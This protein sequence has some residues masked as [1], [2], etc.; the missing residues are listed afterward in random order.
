VSFAV[1]MALLITPYRRS[2]AE[3]SSRITDEA[4]AIWMTPAPVESVEELT[5]AD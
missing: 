5:T 2:T 4:V 3:T 1:S